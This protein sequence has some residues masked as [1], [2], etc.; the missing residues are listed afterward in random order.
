[1]DLT[2]LWSPLRTYVGG[3]FAPIYNILA[4]SLN[5]YLLVVAN[6][7]VW[8][9]HFALRRKLSQFVA[10]NQRPPASRRDK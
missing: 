1:M 10:Q 4:H 7:I 2:T 3:L 6:L 9:L 8:P 5:I